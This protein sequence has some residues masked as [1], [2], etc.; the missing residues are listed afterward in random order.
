MNPLQ[1][2]IQYECLQNLANGACTPPSVSPPLPDGRTTPVAPLA[3]LKYTPN[4]GSRPRVGRFFLLRGAP[5]FF[6]AR[7]F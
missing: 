4:D 7:A 5:F 3:F 1:F 2:E 6:F